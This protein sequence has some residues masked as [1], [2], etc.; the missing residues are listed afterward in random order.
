MVF[1]AMCVFVFRRTNLGIFPKKPKK[2][3]FFSYFCTYILI[4]VKKLIIVWAL[5]IVAFFA[6]WALFAFLFRRISERKEKENSS[7]EE[8]EPHSA[9]KD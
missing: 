3:V 5:G 4:M 7:S 8:A 2:G 1:I 6:L 9:D